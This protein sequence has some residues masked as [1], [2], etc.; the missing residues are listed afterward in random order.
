MVSNRV[1]HVLS[2]FAVGL[3]LC[4]GGGTMKQR[5]RCRVVSRNSAE[6][7]LGRIAKRIVP[8]ARVDPRVR[9][10]GIETHGGAPRA[11]ERS[12]PLDVFQ[13]LLADARPDGHTVGVSPDHSAMLS[14]SRVFPTRAATIT[15]C[16]ASARGV[17]RNVAGS[18]TPR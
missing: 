11:Q 8:G 6:E 2:L 9:L 7:L 15:M 3:E 1:E 5:F 13:T 12:N 16:P 14:M 18:T 10:I 17:R 4:C